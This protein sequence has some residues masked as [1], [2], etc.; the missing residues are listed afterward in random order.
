M[1]A[2]ERLFLDGEYEGSVSRAYYAMYHA[3]RAALSMVDVFPKTREGVVSE[4][5]REF[6]LAGIFQKELGRNLAEAKA[7]GETYE[8]SVAV[9]AGKSEVE[10]ILSNASWFCE[11]S[12][13]VCGNLVMVSSLVASLFLCLSIKVH[14]SMLKACADEG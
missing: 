9:T 7:A 1:R 11:G 13:E 2:V 6:V 10:M 5:G 12:E 4:F 8:Y 3:A 14:L